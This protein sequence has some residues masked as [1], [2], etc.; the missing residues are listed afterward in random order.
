MSKEADKVIMIDGCFLQCIGRILKNQ[1]DEEKVI[2]IDAE[3][4]MDGTGCSERSFL[5]F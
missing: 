2:H 4:L 5:L 3:E 1:V